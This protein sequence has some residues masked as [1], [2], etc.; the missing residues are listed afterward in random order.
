MMTKQEREAWAKRTAG[1]AVR[2]GEVL[3]SLAEQTK[4]AKQARPSDEPTAAQIPK[5]PPKD[6]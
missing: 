6:V 2:L 4:R 5:S 3:T 1:K